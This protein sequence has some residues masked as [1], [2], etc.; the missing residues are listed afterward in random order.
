MCHFFRNMWKCHRVI[1]EINHQVEN[2]R[3]NKNTVEISKPFGFWVDVGDVIAIP[4]FPS[5][6]FFSL[7]T[8][9]C[10]F[11]GDGICC[12]YHFFLKNILHV[13]CLKNISWQNRPKSWLSNFSHAKSKNTG[14]FEVA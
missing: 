7:R 8:Q 14:S 11:L 2:F 5:S 10:C 6:V 13:F 4:L 1:N 3:L 12:R 9:L